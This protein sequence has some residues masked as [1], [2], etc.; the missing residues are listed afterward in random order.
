[1]KRTHPP[2]ELPGSP[3]IYVV[4][5]VSISAVV[6]IERYVPEIQ[7]RLRMS[8]YPSYTNVQVPEIIFEAVG[9]GPVVTTLSRYEFQNKSERTGI[10]LTPKSIAVHTNQYTTFD[11]FCAVIEMALETVHTTA[12]LQLHERIGLRYVDLIELERAEELKDYLPPHLLG[13]DQAAIGIAG[14]QFNFEFEGNTPYGRLVAR[15]YTPQVRNM[16]PPDLAGVSLNYSYRT[17]PSPRKAV[18]LDFDHASDHKGDFVIEEIL[19]TLENLHDGLDIIF[20]NSVTTAA[21]EKWGR[22][23]AADVKS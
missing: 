4:A 12:T 11:E 6:A 19:E 18:L 13:Y 1:M 3:L 23:N 8:G 17:A 16:F 7:E 14:G 9:A 21:L 10:V 22:K 15:H 2:L 20:R 5:Q